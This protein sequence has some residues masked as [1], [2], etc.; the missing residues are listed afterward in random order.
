MMFHMYCG[1][2]GQRIVSVLATPSD[3]VVEKFFVWADK[4]Y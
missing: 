2:L 1:C 4:L 3:L